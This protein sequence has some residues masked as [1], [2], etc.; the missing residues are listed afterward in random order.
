MLSRRGFLAASM[1]VGAASR[2]RAQTGDAAPTVL[3]LERRDIEV[4]GKSASVFCVRQPDGTFGITTDVGKSFRVRVENHIEEPSLIHWHGLAPPWRQDGVQDVSG[5]AIPPGSSAGYD[6]PLRRGGTYWMHS[7][8][9]M[10]EQLLLSAPLIIR[11][12]SETP[13][14]QEVVVMLADFSFTPPHQILAQLQSRQTHDMPS[15]NMHGMDMHGAAMPAIKSEP[16]LNDVQYDAFLANSRTL[17]DP[18]VVRVEPGGQVRLRIVNASSMS[19]YHFDLGPLEGD[20]IA[21]DGAPVQPVRG[22]TFP[23]TVAQRLDIELTIPENAAA[24]PVLAVLEGERRQTGIVLL[25]GKGQI[26]RVSGMADAAS[27]P[28]TLGLERSLRAA[29]PLVERKADRA[30]VV[31]LTGSMQGYRWS[32]NN[33]VWTKDVPPLMVAEGERVELVIIN[34]TMMPHPMH[35]HGHSFQVVAIDGHRFA[36][37]VRDTVLVPPKATVTVAFDADNPGWWAF[38]CHL[39]YHQ[40]AGMFATLRYD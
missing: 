21:V 40:H 24:Y 33:V 25:A 38:H 34:Q 28:L 4:N 17:A 36:G 2:V 23:I 37:A 30:H 27:P 7:H 32:I 19:A 39:L 15:M 16:D 22:R 29:A 8:Y 18:E 35:L 12:G 26:T 31:N 20:L 10:Q 1:A 5:P 11:D 3:R 14:Q 13:S 9:G 6:F